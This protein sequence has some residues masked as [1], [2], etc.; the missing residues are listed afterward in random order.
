MTVHFYPVKLSCFAEKKKVH[1][2]Y[3]NF[4]RGDPNEPGQ[5]PLIQ[6]KNFKSQTFFERFSA[7]NPN[8]IISLILLK[9]VQVMIF[10]IECPNHFVH[11]DIDGTHCVCLRP[12]LAC[13]LWRLHRFMGTKEMGTGC[14]L[15]PTLV[16]EYQQ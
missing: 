3:Q 10:N 7:S 14:N 8:V 9:V 15:S 12:K 13:N 6:T 11:D 1:R 4:I 2:K 5:M 16:A